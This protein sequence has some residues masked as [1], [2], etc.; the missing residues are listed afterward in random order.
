MQKINAC[1]DASSATDASVIDWAAWCAQRLG[2]PLE[3]LHV[4]EATPGVESPADDLTGAI[5]LGAHETLLARLSELDAQRSVV[6]HQAGA[7][8]LDAA[9]QRA[10]SAGVTQVGTRMRQQSLAEALHALEPETRLFVLG[11]HPRQAGGRLPAIDHHIEAVVRSVSRPVLIATQAP[12]QPLE[13][14]FIAFD[15]S[16]TAHKLVAAVAQSPLLVGLPIM[17]VKAAG[18]GADNK[19]T[20]S[21]LQVAESALKK[22]GAHQDV[23]STVIAGQPDEVLPELLRQQKASLLVMGAYGHSRIRQ[24]LVGSTTTALMRS[25]PVPVLVLR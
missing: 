13:R 11:R 8:L 18:A 25:S 15:G 23:S 16:P 14:I 6:A 9:R 22:G 3:L 2:A 12:F 4:I 7:L 21:Q 10:E 20:R 17:L 1:I 19:A 24:F 5:G